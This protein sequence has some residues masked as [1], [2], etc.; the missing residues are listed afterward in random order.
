MKKFGL[1]LIVLSIVLV[2]FQ[3]AQAKKYEPNYESLSQWQVPQWFEDAV[4]G[5]YV[6]WGPYSVP[7]FAFKLPSERV[8]S[9]QPRVHAELLHGGHV[10]FGHLDVGN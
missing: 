3:Q 10:G 1:V 7:G 4:L 5:V 6:H 8:D 9:G 2:C